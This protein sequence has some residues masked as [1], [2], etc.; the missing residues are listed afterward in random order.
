M[1]LFEYHQSSRTTRNNGDAPRACAPRSCDSHAAL[2]LPEE[3][4]EAHA[5][6]VCIARNTG[7]IEQRRTE[8][9]HLALERHR[10]RD[11]KHGDAA[12]RKEEGVNT[13][14]TLTLMRRG[15]RG[16]KRKGTEKERKGKTT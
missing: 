7:A 1:L 11:A 12:T 3:R 8:D 15:D 10:Q 5:Q 4:E 13:T 9:D 2:D 16:G 6:L 14:L